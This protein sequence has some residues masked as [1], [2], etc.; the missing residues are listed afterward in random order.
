MILFHVHVHFYASYTSITT[1]VYMYMHDSEQLIA[2]NTDTLLTSDG[3]TK[4]KLSIREPI[5]DSHHK[6]EQSAHVY[7]IKIRF[8]RIM[9]YNKIE[10]HNMNANK[11]I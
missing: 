7:A 6:H 3:D 9:P 2:V 10:F 5:N 8:Q 4:Q 11:L 1:L